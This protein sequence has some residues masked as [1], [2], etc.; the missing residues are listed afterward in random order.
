MAQ[1]CGRSADRSFSKLLLEGQGEGAY[2]LQT[3]RGVL[4]YRRREF[5]TFIFNIKN[6]IFAKFGGD[7]LA[8]LP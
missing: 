6:E 3:C 8:I 2:T 7:V 4:K 5:G 1:L